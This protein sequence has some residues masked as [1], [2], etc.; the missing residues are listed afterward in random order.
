MRFLYPYYS[1]LLHW[2]CGVY[3]VWH[4]SDIFITNI[5]LFL[6]VFYVDWHKLTSKSS[7]ANSVNYANIYQG[8]ILNLGLNHMQ[9]AAFIS[10]QIKNVWF[11]PRIRNMSCAITYI[12]VHKKLSCLW[13]VHSWFKDKYIGA[14][15][16]CVC[17]AVAC[18]TNWQRG[19][20]VFMGSLFNLLLNE[21]RNC[22][23]ATF[24]KKNV[25]KSVLYFTLLLR[26][27]ISAKYCW[28]GWWLGA[29][30]TLSHHPTQLCDIYIFWL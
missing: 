14:N 6:L 20:Q 27:P 18:P 16:P 26:T 5:I 13:Q 7:E 3:K 21:F 9:Y 19:W 8:F 23:R 4:I 24:R 12:Y 28:F 1:V 22:W 2:R 11:V 10:N 29:W 17:L 25:V 15:H 30:S